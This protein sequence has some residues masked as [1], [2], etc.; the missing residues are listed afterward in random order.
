MENSKIQ[1][2]AIIDAVILPLLLLAASQSL[3][4]Q[5]AENVLL[6]VNRNDAFSVEIG[7]YY[8]Q[9]RAIPPENVCSIDSFLFEEISWQ[10]YLDGVERPIAACLAS[11]AFQEKVLY[12]VTTRGVPLKILGGG[13]AFESESASVDSELT[14][15]YGKLHGRQYPRAGTVPNPFFGKLDAV[16]R[17]PTYPIYLV[18]RLGAWD[19]ADAKGMIDR[20]LAAKN[21]GK[22]VFDL[23]GTYDDGDKWLRAAARLLPAHR[24]ILDETPE[25]LY[26]QKNV[27]GYASWGSNDPN[28]KSRRVN[29]GWLPGAVVSDFVSTNGR[30]LNQPPYDW[31]FPTNFAGS[32]QSLSADYLREGATAATGSV[33][34]PFLTGTVRPDY[35][36]PA[37]YRGRNLAESY[38]LAMPFLSWQG[39]ILGDPLCSLGKP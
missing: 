10:M 20:S 38:Y 13:L 33:Y 5:T 22:F 39:I 15:L 18:T 16:F 17:H 24:V 34:E 30:T 7:E 4:A 3:R 2:L 26:Q 35:F 36:F 1:A 27:I 32:T 14:L 31:V 28:R 29:F 12:I 8:R 6:V 19:M 9:R 25:V 37:Y 23:R 11:P 21:T